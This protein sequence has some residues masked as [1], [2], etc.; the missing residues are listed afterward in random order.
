MELL[1]QAADFGTYTNWMPPNLSEHGERID[2][3]IDFLHYFMAVLFVGWGIF[4]EVA[5][6]NHLFIAQEGECGDGFTELGS[7]EIFS[8]KDFNIH[9]AELF[10]KSLLPAMNFLKA[11]I[12]VVTMEEVACFHVFKVP[13]W[14]VVFILIF[15][16]IYFYTYKNPPQQVMKRGIG[17]EWFWALIVRLRFDSG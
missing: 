11:G 4:E 14:T 6:D 13:C 10:F 12:T 9:V 16:E 2:S 8:F 17:W 5:D 7:G 1:A 15:D 3:L